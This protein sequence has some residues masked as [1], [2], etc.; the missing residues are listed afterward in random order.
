MKNKKRDVDTLCTAVSDESSDSLRACLRGRGRGGRL[1]P[2]GL[3]WRLAHAGFLHDCVRLWPDG[4]RQ[5]THGE[6]APRLDTTK[7][8]LRKLL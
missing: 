4:N 3:S 6:R 5:D 2:G 8:I 7:E 1:L